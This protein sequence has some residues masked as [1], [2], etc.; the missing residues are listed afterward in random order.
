MANF[1]IEKT[2]NGLFNNEIELTG[3]YATLIRKFKDDIGL[4]PVFRDCYM[5]A[6]ILG[7]LHGRTESSDKTPSVQN[8]SIFSDALR[9][10]KSELK[11]I[12]RL[13]MLS[14]DEPTFSIDDYMN[15]TFRDDIEDPE[16]AI[17]LK[18]NMEMFHSYVCGGLDYLDEKFS[19][20]TTEDAMVNM[21]Y[22]IVT[23]FAQEVGLLDA[24]ESELPDF[25]PSF[26]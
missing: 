5:V 6:A 19:G 2:N 21:I 4:F 13:M 9:T 24:D 7:Y 15:R 20:L 3:K 26:N 16:G 14:K 10:R 23:E 25:T 8:A 22:E 17:R 11:F 18:E 1:I 12:Y